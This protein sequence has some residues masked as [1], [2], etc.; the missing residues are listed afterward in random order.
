MARTPIYMTDPRFDEISAKVRNSYPNAC[1]LFIDEINNINLYEAYNNRKNEIETKRGQVT[2]M[3]LFHGTHAHLIDKIAAEGFDP[4]K[5]A[6]A[7]FG[8]GTYFATTAA[9]SFNYMKTTDKT[10][11]S[12]MFL[13]DVL[14]GKKIRN[15]ESQDF[16]N[17]VDNP[18]APSIIVSPYGDGCFPRYVIAF[19]KNASK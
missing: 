18:N 16:D 12:Y 6:V 15:G 3:Q 2:E 17:Y 8:S 11:I 13:A 4:S 19:H 9:Y 14:I 7:A 10:G 5:S 1:I